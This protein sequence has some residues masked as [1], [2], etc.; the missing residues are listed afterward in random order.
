MR[1]ALSSAYSLIA[2]TL[3]CALSVWLIRISPS[4]LPQVIQKH[5]TTN[6]M[7]KHEKQCIS[8]GWYV[9]TKGKT[10]EGDMVLAPSTHGKGRRWH[11]CLCV[12]L[13][14]DNAGGLIYRRRLDAAPTFWGFIRNVYFRYFA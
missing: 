1:S 11:R 4:E 14:V 5:N 7:T 8:G 9:V 10:M 13:P 6:N 3:G 2:R 12:G